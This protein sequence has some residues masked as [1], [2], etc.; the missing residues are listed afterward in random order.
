MQTESTNKFIPSRPNFIDNKVVV[1]DGLVGGGKGLISQIISALPGVE[2][3]VHRPQIEQV[4]GLHYLSHISMEGAI[5]LIKTWVDEEAYNISMLRNTNCR[6][7]DYSSIFK[8]PRKLSY[9]FR[10]FQKGRQSSMERFIKNKNIL[11]VM[12][13]AN[14]AYAEPIF[15]ALEERLIYIRIVRSPVSA[16]YIY[17]HL[18]QWSKRWGSD[19][20]SGML[21]YKYNY[22]NN[23]LYMPYFV[24][25]NEVLEYYQASEIDKAIYM[26]KYWQ[27]KGDSSID[28]MKKKYNVKI[29]EI[30]F[31][32]F[33]FNPEMFIDTVASA[34]QVK[35][36]KVVMREM[37]KQKV[38]RKTI[39][40]APAID[41]YNEV[42]WKK[43][44]AN[45]SLEDEFLLTKNYIKEK[46]S[47]SAYK[48][49]EKIY[50]TY[51]ERYAIF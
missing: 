3:W 19:I 32:K 15:Q 14:T 7:S 30:P 26:L 48:E 33:V 36:D 16:E 1:V 23:N 13:H 49:L 27:N 8:Y 22:N 18:G 41:A 42:G 50:H 38:P 12:T 9:M 17:N 39:S 4:C 5:T 43:P 21:L 2:M 47:S 46:A 34:L 40:D 20:R 11:N 29:I 31:E 37:K 10:F 45:I 25:I 51:I 35:V 6:P 44:K 28:K 24:D